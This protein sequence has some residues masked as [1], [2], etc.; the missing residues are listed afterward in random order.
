MTAEEKG[1]A[2]VIMRSLE[3][4]WDKGPAGRRALCDLRDICRGDI[5]RVTKTSVNLLKSLILVEDDGSVHEFVRSVV[6]RGLEGEGE[7]IKL[8]PPKIMR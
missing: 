1:G 3:F 4:L 7:N 6:E 5:S 8:V 2:I